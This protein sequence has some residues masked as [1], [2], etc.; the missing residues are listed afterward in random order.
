MEIMYFGTRATEEMIKDVIDGFQPYQEPIFI[1]GAIIACGYYLYTHKNYVFARHKYFMEQLKLATTGA[2]SFIS[3][4]KK[5]TLPA[6]RNYVPTKTSK[7]RLEYLEE[8]TKVKKH[9]DNVL[10]EKFEELFLKDILIVLRMYSNISDDHR[11]KFRNKF[12]DLIE[13]TL[14]ANEKVILSYNFDSINTFKL[15]VYNHFTLRL[16]RLEMH[17]SL[18]TDDDESDDVKSFKY[19]NI[20]RKIFDQ[21][22]NKES[23]K[24]ITHLIE[25]YFKEGKE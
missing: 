8:I 24:D 3:K 15:Y 25:N 17:L 14:T 22:S 1:S 13:V 11:L 18:G 20:Y 16:L 23:D 19:F 7:E 9:L 4:F 10:D 12:L 2:L 21:K 6:P 5:K